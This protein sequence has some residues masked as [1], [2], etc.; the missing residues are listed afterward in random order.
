M[1]DAT[2]D[3]VVANILAEVILEL[4]DQVNRVLKP[5]GVFI[6]S[7]II[8]AFQSGVIKKMAARGFSILDVQKQGDWVAIAGRIASE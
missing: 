6:C 4:L 2:Y 8:E 3:I 5:G 1:V 7:G